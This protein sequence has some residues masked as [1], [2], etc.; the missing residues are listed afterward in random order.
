MPT[1]VKFFT[2]LALYPTRNSLEHLAM[3]TGK[4]PDRFA[5]AGACSK[6]GTAINSTRQSKKDV[7]ATQPLQARHILPF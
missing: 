1:L 4:M 5:Q 2:G 7:K 3:V 6:P